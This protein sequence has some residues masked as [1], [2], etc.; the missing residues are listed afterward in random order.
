MKN[1]LI[2]TFI[3]AS[4][5]GCQQ[6]E[7]TDT[8]RTVSYSMYQATSTPVRGNVIF[9]ELEEGKVQVEISLQNTLDEVKH[10]AHLHFGTVKEL[11]ELAF[12][13]NSVD[14]S[15]G[16]STTILDQVQLSNGEI[17]TFDK[18]YEMNGSVKIHM[19]ETF[20]KDRVLSFGNIG[21][22]ENYDVGGMTICTG[23]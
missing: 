3:A 22:N 7:M 8:K 17:F 20:F 9:T 19:S 4:T 12:A 1:F 18:L 21:K 16:K 23:H 13:L 6:Q 2:L 15:T 11:G 10:P 5:F 14:G